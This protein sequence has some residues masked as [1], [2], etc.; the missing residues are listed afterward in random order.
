MSMV[1][2]LFYFLGLHVIQKKDK[3]FMSQYKYARNLVKKFGLEK[4]SHKRTPAETDVKL[5]ND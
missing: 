2:E 3:T 4:A 1:G 5:S